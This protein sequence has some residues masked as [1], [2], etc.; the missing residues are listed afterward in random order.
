MYRRLD[1]STDLGKK[2]QKAKDGNDKAYEDSISSIDGN[3]KEGQVAVGIA[4]G[5]NT[6]DLPNGDACPVWK[7]TMQQALIKKSIDTIEAE[8]K[9]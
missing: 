1:T 8:E 7:K 4:K 5:C 9:V 6:K 3:I 2:E